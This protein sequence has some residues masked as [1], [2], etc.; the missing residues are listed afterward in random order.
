MIDRDETLKALKSPEGF[1]IIKEIFIERKQ[2]EDQQ[3]NAI[4]SNTDYIIWLEKF[5]TK[6]PDFNNEIFYYQKEKLSKEDIKNGEMLPIFYDAIENYAEQNRIEPINVSGNF[7]DEY[8][9]LKFQ[10][11]GFHIGC[12]CGQGTLYY[13]EKKTPTTNFIDFEDI[14]ISKRKTFRNQVSNN[15][16]KLTKLIHEIADSTPLDE[17]SKTTENTIQKILQKRNTSL[18]D[19]K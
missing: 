4:L 11:V 16:E 7:Q 6:Y 13:V 12:M 10:G 5:T 1:K 3:K 14:L 19:H 9:Q 15:L 18:A 2:K 8:Y 17:I